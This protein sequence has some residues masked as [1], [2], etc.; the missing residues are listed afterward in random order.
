MQ[1]S[2]IQGLFT[3]FRFELPFTAGVC[4][5][6]GELLALGR[7]P[8][9]REMVLGFLSVFCIS[10]AALI[11]NDYFDTEKTVP[12]LSI[13]KFITYKQIAIQQIT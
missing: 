12:Q 6:F 13:Y 5:I 9:T 10:A 3:L 4:L 11:L 8:S 7:L 2:K 1:R